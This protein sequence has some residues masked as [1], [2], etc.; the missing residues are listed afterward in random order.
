MSVVEKVARRL[1]DF[2]ECS[3]VGKG[4]AGGQMTWH[5]CGRSFNSH[6]EAKEHWELERARAALLAVAS[7]VT[8]EMGRVA[9]TA[10]YR[11]GACG[12]DGEAQDMRDA[13]AKS[14]RAALGGE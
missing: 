14:I 3:I 5:T 10:W 2:G 9:R 7:N 8:D 1:A 11:R 6:G 4:Y 13:I 12:P